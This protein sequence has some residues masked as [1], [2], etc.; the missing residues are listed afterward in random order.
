MLAFLQQIANI[1]SSVIGFVVHGIQ[2]IVLVL[3]T[4][5]QAVLFIVEAI[6]Q[7]PLFV[8]APV[9]VSISIAVILF[10]INKGSAG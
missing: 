5:I 1:I 6:A 8:I 7:L 9:T 3:N 2:M 10:I 4:M